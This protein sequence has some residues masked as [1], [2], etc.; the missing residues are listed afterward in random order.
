MKRILLPAILASLVAGSPVSGLN[1]GG[2]LKLS[3]GGFYNSSNILDLPQQFEGKLEGTVGDPAFPDARYQV[4]VRARTKPFADGS[5]FQLRE[6]WVKA[7]LG[8][9]D[10]SFGNQIVT[11]GTTDLFSPEDLLNASDY[12]LP[13]D[14]E[15]IPALL[16]RATA[17]GRSWSL[18]LVGLPFWTMP[19]LPDARWLKPAL[20]P[21]MGVA[22]VRTNLVTNAPAAAWSNVQFGARF[23]ASVDVFQGID[24]GVEYFQGF[25]SIPVQTFS[26][27]PAGTPGAMI[28]EMDLSFPRYQMIG[29]DLTVVLKEGLVFRA[30]GGYKT[31]DGAAWFADATNTGAVQAVAAL[32]YPFFGIR[33]ILEYVLEWGNWGGLMATGGATSHTGLLILSRDFGS[34][35]SA[36]VAGGYRSDSSFFFVPQVQITLADG[37]AVQFRTYLFFGEDGT[38]YGQFRDN[39]YGEMNMQFSF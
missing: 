24:L 20:S 6:A 39:K 5:L 25:R 11:W 22:I 36:K 32:E 33:A 37:L 19:T 34:R 28:A 13:F 9:I 18:D 35:L 3:L 16:L 2:S 4:K 30:E 15:K 27:R 10:L 12:T 1:L 31:Y 21:P 7:F 14:A 17:R 26:M 23:K 29:A 8:P 38:T